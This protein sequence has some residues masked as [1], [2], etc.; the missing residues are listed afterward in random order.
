MERA[1]LRTRQ[2]EVVCNST[3]EKKDKSYSVSLGNLSIGGVI[4]ASL[5]SCTFRNVFYNVSEGFNVFYMNVNGITQE[6]TIPVGQYSVIELLPI[7]KDAIDAYFVGSGI[8]PI[9]T[10][11]ELTYDSITAKITMS[12]N[13]NGSVPVIYLQPQPTSLNILLGNTQDTD[14]FEPI[15]LDPITFDSIINLGGIDSVN[16]VCQ[17]IGQTRGIVNNEVDNGNGRVFSLVRH[18]PI[19]KSFGQ[20]VDYLESDVD[21]VAVEFTN[22]IDLTQMDIALQT[23]RGEN[24]DLS[25][26]QMTCEWILKVIQ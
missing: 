12:I 4:T 20:Q 8:V 1:N 15:A 21:A 17:Q 16:L 26:T 7:L 6:I 25:N 18:I 10:I 5:K 13:G 2:L 22:P 19:V 24:L 14:N 23:T 11:E 9:P 3:N